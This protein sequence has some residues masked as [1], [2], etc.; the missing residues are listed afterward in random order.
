MFSNRVKCN[1]IYTNSV[2]QSKMY[3]YIHYVII[4]TY[5]SVITHTT[6]FSEFWLL[7]EIFIIY[8]N[9]FLFKKCLWGGGDCTPPKIRHYAD[10]CKDDV[11]DRVK[12]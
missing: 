5:L 10:V 4:Y 12:W 8:T 9:F 6:L 2:L 1:P 11:E 3:V 7:S